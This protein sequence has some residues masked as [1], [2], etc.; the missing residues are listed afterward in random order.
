MGK[1]NKINKK[2][3]KHKLIKSSVILAVC[4]A[5]M[6]VIGELNAR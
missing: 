4:L 3:I 6:V 5:G 1:Q 2:D